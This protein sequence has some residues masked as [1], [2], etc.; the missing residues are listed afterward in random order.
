MCIFCKII[1]NDIKSYKIFESK[2]FIAILDIFPIEKYHVLLIT[3]KH[4]E[5]F[6]DADDKIMIN[7]LKY[8]KKICNKIKDNS[9]AKGFNIIT[10]INKIAGQEIF[11]FHWHIIPRYVGNKTNYITKRLKINNQE[12]K[13][14]QEKIKFKN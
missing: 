7:S 5:N 6:L 10:N 2:N 8:I 12:I 9:A 3:K 4:F 11:H 14:M 1:T 13:K